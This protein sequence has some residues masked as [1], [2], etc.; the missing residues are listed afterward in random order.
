MRRILYTLALV[1]PSLLL[2]QKGDVEIGGNIGI[3]ASQIGFQSNVFDSKIGLNMQGEAFVNYF[4]SDNI[5]LSFGLGINCLNSMAT[6][7]NYQSTISEG[8]DDVGDYRILLYADN[9]QEIERLT[10]LDIPIGLVFRKAIN[11]NWTFR[12]GV[13]FKIGLSLAATYQSDQG[14]STRLYYPNIMKDE[15]E[16]IHD[17]PSWGMYENRTDWDQ[18]SGD[19]ETQINLSPFVNIGASYKLQNHLSLYC[20]FYAAYGINDV[21]SDNEKHLLTASI[22]AE[23]NYHSPTTFCQN[24]TYEMGV[25][26]GV[27]FDLRK[28]Q[29]VYN[30]FNGSGYKPAFSL[31]F[32]QKG[33]VEIG[34]NIG[35]GTSK[36]GLQSDV[37]NSKMGLNLQGEAFVNYFLSDN[38]GMSLGFGINSLSAMAT[39]ANY[40]SIVSEGADD[41]GKYQILVYAD[42]YQENQRLTMLEIPIGLVFRK[43]MSKDWTFRAGAGL[44]ISL[45]IAATYQLDQGM[46]TRL[47]YPNIMKD[48]SESIYDIPSWGMYENRTDW[49]Q[50]SGDL[51]ALIN[52]SPFA[53]IGASYELHNNLS[54]Y[55]GLYAAYGINDVV[56]DSEQ[57]LLTASSN[58]E[59]NYHS[60]TT[61]SQNNTFEMGIKIGTLFN[62]RKKRKVSVHFNGSGYSPS[63][64]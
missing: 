31:L 14:M 48:E 19:L 6:A 25:K 18:S 12:A 9:Y 60:P 36:I 43:A 20:G 16:S 40:R 37:I 7:T 5:G 45:P 54:L 62:L 3:G 21:V 1:I 63:R 51:E 22:D 34:G 13:G 8:S 47:Y 23:Y 59:Y 38:L 30:Y 15:S 52:L 28:K 26:V 27:L 49:N 41:I 29:N 46:S 33:N 17:I 24:N 32:A 64:R 10:M 44:K 35:I 53:N 56:S 57:Q 58:A 50:S 2:A 39:A 4:F 42:N 55:C 61:F 11:E